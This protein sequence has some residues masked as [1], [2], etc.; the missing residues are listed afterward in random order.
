[1]SP[2]DPVFLLSPPCTFSWVVAAI[3]GRHEQTYAVPELHLFRTETVGE[4]LE[5]CDAESFEMDHGLVRAVA[6]LCFGAQTEPTAAAARG[7]LQRRAH[8]TTGLLLEQLAERVAPRVLV[9]RSPSHVYSATILG[10]ILQMFPRARF[11]HLTGHPRAF[12]ETVMDA[13]AQREGSD[14]SHSD[15]VAQL[16]SFPG[17]VPG[18]GRHDPQRAWLALH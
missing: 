10:R 14:P 18:A 8:Q 17:E 7:W 5:L 1:M 12:G 2:P 4:W 11:V 6:Q 15:W 9:E 16:A 3:L 13:L